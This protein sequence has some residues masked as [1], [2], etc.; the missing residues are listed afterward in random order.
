MHRLAPLLAILAAACTPDQQIHVLYPTLTVAPESVDFG[1]VVVD[2]E[3]TSELEIINSGDATLDVTEVKVL[4]TTLPVFGVAVEPFSL[5]PDDR[6]RFGIT[7]TPSTYSTYANTL[8]IASNDPDLPDFQVPLSCNGVK[9]PTPDIEISDTS[10]EFGSCD[11]PQEPGTAATLWFT[12]DNVGTGDLHITSTTQ[13]GSGRF[14]VITDPDGTTIQA[15][16]EGFPVLVSYIPDDYTGDNGTLTIESDDPDEPVTTVQ[17]LGNCGGDFVY[18][19]AVIDAPES[20][21]PLL[22]VELDGRESYD[23]TGYSLTY[24]WSLLDQPDGSRSEITSATSDRA[25]LYT[26]LAGDYQVQLVVVNE[27]G[28]RSAPAKHTLQAIPAENLRIEMYWDTNNSDMDLH[29]TQ[30]GH[31]MFEPDYD[32]NYCEPNPEWGEGGSEDDPR[33]DLDD[34]TGYGPENINIDAPADGEYDIYAHYFMDNGGG[35]STVTIKVYLDRVAVYT[36]SMVLAHNEVWHV[37]SIH[38]PERWVEEDETAEPYEA[39]IRSCP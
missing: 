1:D 27:L 18:P 11:V 19:V 5:E 25:S 2:Y 12:V 39:A 29:L 24:D 26:D 33:L 3:A 37:G 14:T 34:R 30:A 36:G 13:T 10:I 6:T 4:D 17:L 21:Q 35:G 31:E 9:A 28:V 32:C 7:C 16:E 8:S 23:P 38:W 15:G 22:T 20:T